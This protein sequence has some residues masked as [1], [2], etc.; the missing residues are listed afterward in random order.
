M[1]DT[2]SCTRQPSLEHELPALKAGKSHDKKG[3]ISECCHKVL[4]NAETIR[5]LERL[6]GRG[7]TL[8]DDAI[9]ILNTSQTN[10]DSIIYQLF[11][12]DVLRFC[13]SGLVLLCASSLG[14]QRVVHLAAKDRTGLV[15][16]LRNN[17]AK[18]LSPALETL[19]KK[20]KVPTVK[21]PQLADNVAGGSR[22]RVRNDAQQSPPRKRNSPQQRLCASESDQTQ[23][24]SSTNDAPEPT[25]AQTG[26][27]AHCSNDV[28][29][30]DTSSFDMHPFLDLQT[31]DLFNFLEK[32]QGEDRSLR[33]MCPYA[34]SPLPWIEI[35]FKRSEIVE[36]NIQI[37]WLM[38]RELIKFVIENK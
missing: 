33:M 15:G 10:R 13:G 29:S 1:A 11:L 3:G 8:V 30:L 38:S 37:S 9:G 7:P 25:I 17:K 16:Y 31:A 18:L 26:T 22:K 6:T 32:H 5:I 19:A 12:H 36:A 21:D 35:R 4:E 23:Q 34:G 2:D 24:T 20:Y 14:K 27:P 28:S